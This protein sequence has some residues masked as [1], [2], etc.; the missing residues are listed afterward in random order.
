MHVHDLVD[1]VTAESQ[2]AGK[3]AATFTNDKA[4][5]EN[6]EYIEII[7]K[8]NITYTVPQRVRA[9]NVDKNCQIFFRVN[10]IMESCNITIT[11]QNQ[12]IAKFKK[13]HLAPGE[14]VTITLPKS[15]LDKINAKTIEISALEVV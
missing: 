11:C 8:D 12:V 3:S 13:Q 10:K 7:N 1:F 9:N 15:I 14:M 2:K 6:Q 4:S 5:L